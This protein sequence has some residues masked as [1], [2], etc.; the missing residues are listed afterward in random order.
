VGALVPLVFF[1]LPAVWF[2]WFGPFAP[3]AFLFAMVVATVTTG[4]G[5]LLVWAVCTAYS[6]VQSGLVVPVLASALVGLAATFLG[7]V[8][9][10][11]VLVVGLTMAWMATPDPNAGLAPN[12]WK[13]DWNGPHAPIAL[14]ATVLAFG[15]WTTA[16]LIAAIGGPMT[17]AYLYQ[18]QGT[19]KP[20]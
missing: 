12:R 17:A 19:L 20:R 1:A 15:I 7:G 18:E 5:G 2:A 14:G 13:T 3:F 10:T 11:G 4:L 9:A 6:D 16:V 8:V